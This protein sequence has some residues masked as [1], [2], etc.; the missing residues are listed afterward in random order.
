MLLDVR[1]DHMRVVLSVLRT[2][3]P[4]AEVFAFGSRAKWNAKDSSDLDLCVRAGHPLGFGLMG[5]LLDAF[6][7]SSL[8]YKVDVVDWETISP[9]F[10]KIIEKDKVLIYSNDD[11]QASGLMATEYGQLSTSLSR[12]KLE[13]LCEKGGVQ[14]GPFGSQLHKD[15]YVDDGIPII[16]VEHL[17]ENRLV[18]ENLP[19]VSTDDYQRLSKYRLK[20]GDIVFSR[21]GSVD[22]RAIVQQQEDGWLFSGR[23]LRVRP[24]PEKIDSTWLSYFFGLPSFKEYIRSIAVGAT[25]P[26]LNTKILSDVPIYFPILAEQQEIGRILSALDDKVALLRETNKTLEA[27]AQALFKS[28]FVD[29]DPVRAKSEG[30]EPEGVPPEIAEFFPSEF[31]TA[32]LGEIPRGWEVKPVYDLAEYIN[33]AAY[34]AFSPNSDKRGFPII[35][36]AELKSGIT[37]QTAYSDVAMPEK[38]SLET[39]DI[40]FSWSGNPDTSIDTFVWHYG[41]AW[42]NQHIFKVVVNRT[43]ERSFVLQ[44]LKYLRPV[45][46]EIARNKQ[47]TGLGHVTVADMKRLL[48]VQPDDAVLFAFGELADPIHA[49]IFENELEAITLAELRDALLLKLMAGSLRIETAN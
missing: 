30:R 44:S 13:D 25:M 20:Q 22:R 3:V 34:K 42:L 45:F 6:S 5:D 48:V 37:S 40:L 31:E 10:R 32:K 11:E 24:N 43:A 4:N 33:G 39:G 12:S 14:T 1:P 7:E 17:G 19:R 23:C 47:T 16:T 2:F 41:R 49:R 15:D 21:V 29:F 35:K 18:H 8:P 46:A 36:I 26:S 38:Y 27:L 9:S 28:W